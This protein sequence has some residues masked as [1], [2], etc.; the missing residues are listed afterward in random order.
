[1]ENDTGKVQRTLRQFR[2]KLLA[3]TAACEEE[4]SNFQDSRIPSK[5]LIPASIHRRDSVLAHIPFAILTTSRSAA[6][7][8]KTRRGANGHNHSRSNPLVIAAAARSVVELSTASTPIRRRVKSLQSS[9]QE[10]V[11]TAV[12]EWE[13]NFRSDSLYCNLRRSQLEVYPE[14]SPTT[15]R[16][17]EAKRPKVHSLSEMA[18]FAVARLFAKS[19]KTCQIEEEE[20]WYAVIPELHRGNVLFE[21]VV[22]LCISNVDAVSVFNDLVKACVSGGAFYQGFELLTARMYRFPPSKQHE[23]EWCYSLA[24]RMNRI[25]G[26]FNAL[27][28]MLT[29]E[30]CVSI[31]FWDFLESIDQLRALRLV[32]L[33]IVLFFSDLSAFRPKEEQLCGR[34]QFWVEKLLELEPQDSIDSSKSIFE[35]Y[36]LLADKPLER[37]GLSEELRISVLIKALLLSD[38][39]PCTN[40]RVTTQKKSRWGNAL[41]NML[42]SSHQ[43]LVVSLL[44]SI[45]SL[46]VVVD[47]LR[48]LNQTSSAAQLLIFIINNHHALQKDGDWDTELTLDRLQDELQLLDEYAVKTQHGPGWRYEPVADA[49]VPATPA[50]PLVFTRRSL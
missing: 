37:L 47:V 39:P 17:I 43:E 19:P 25:N 40:L 45:S 38:R 48:D 21:H 26:W 2:S 32:S 16:K 34:I 8:K 41:G 4:P 3:V 36:T 22:Q 30:Q 13:S 15:P 35:I 20:T 33:A 1:M 18:A 23:L 50:K 12:R 11:R 29:V 31:D 28:G 10:L 6:T 42:K 44:G 27:H 5:R 24:R 14:N 46:Y 49:W 9:F 7:Y